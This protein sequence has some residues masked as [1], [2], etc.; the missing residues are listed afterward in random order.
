M[1]KAALLAD[2]QEREIKEMVAHTKANIEQAELDFLLKRKD[3]KL[4]I[5]HDRLQQ[6]L[7]EDLLKRLAQ[8]PIYGAN[9]GI[10]KSKVVF[11][12][13]SFN[14]PITDARLSLC[15]LANYNLILNALIVED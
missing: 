3:G 9:H 7:H 5:L 8:T 10:A 15:F 13:K 6:R 14:P 1:R 12:D 2:I 11:G 4:Q